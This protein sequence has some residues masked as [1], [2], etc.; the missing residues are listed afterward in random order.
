MSVR[1]SSA[2]NGDLFIDDGVDDTAIHRYVDN[3]LSARQR[4]KVEEYLS[5]RPDEARRIADIACQ[6]FGFHQLFDERLSEPLSNEVLKLKGELNKSVEGERT[7]HKVGKYVGG[8]ILCLI[9]FGTGM[10]L[11]R[12]EPVMNL[13]GVLTQS[14]YLPPDVAEK[15]SGEAGDPRAS[16]REDD[17]LPPTVTQRALNETTENLMGAAP[18]DLEDF[19]FRHLA[20]RVLDRDQ[21]T[22]TMQYRYESDK[23][24]FAILYLTAS[25][26]E[27]GQEFRLARHGAISTVEWQRD[28]A[29]FIVVSDL[30]REELL[31]LCHEI[32]GRDP[33]ERS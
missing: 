21:P 11:G 13:T 27:S 7:S 2:G 23:G 29:N 9:L 6:N 17:D 8:G 16:K 33:F 28:G 19:G 15:F 31:S 30:A 5:Q 26:T 14:E 24:R 18:P 1:W 20:T 3:Q 4:I 22:E 25:D 32:S 12:T 10:I